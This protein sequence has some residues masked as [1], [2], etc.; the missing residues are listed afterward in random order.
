MINEVIMKDKKQ[1]V[2][3]LLE[4]QL[5]DIEVGIKFHQRYNQPF[6]P[7]GDSFTEMLHACMYDTLCMG[8]GGSGWDTYDKGESKF[9]NRLQ[10][11]NCNSCKTWDGRVNKN[12][13]KIWNYKKVMFFLSK[14]P[15][16]GSE[17]LG[18]YSKDSRFGIASKSHLEYIDEMKGYRL[19]LLEPETFDS[20]C[21]VF[22]LRSWF[23]ETK[24]KYLTEY[25]T[26]QF[27]SPK[28]N[29][30]NFMPLGQDFYRSSP[31]LHLDATISK[32]G[33]EINYLNTE[34]KEPEIGDEKF[35]K[36]SVEEIMN[37]KSFGKERGELSR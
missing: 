23:I 8:S 33:V 2:K 16:C 28:S 19:T 35:Y 21:R 15:V 14:C 5:G 36:L 34:N 3:E 20:E 17:D 26:R 6:D 30:I 27:N 32:D 31:C 24:D 18:K 25:A 11:R 9:S 29:G 37:K 1:E 13:K 12:G 22:H 10:S 4:Y 7:L